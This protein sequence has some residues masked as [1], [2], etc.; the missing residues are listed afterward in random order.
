MIAKS[1][2]HYA[3]LIILVQDLPCV[4]SRQTNARCMVTGSLLT[5]MHMARDLRAK[6][7]DVLPVAG[8]S[9]A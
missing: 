7:V 1:I 6:G 3:I 4:I 9:N 5:V 8:E 2:P